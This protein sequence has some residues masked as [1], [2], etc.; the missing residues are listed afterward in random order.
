MS[1][2]DNSRQG[3]TRRL[4]NDSVTIG[5]YAKTVE[6]YEKTYQQIE[7]EQQIAGRS[8]DYLSL[9]ASTARD[10]MG[11]EQLDEMRGRTDDLTV[12]LKTVLIELNERAAEAFEINA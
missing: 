4:T 3:L 1:S 6:E 12:H 5:A 11:I 7:R 2:L 9:L 10:R 8:D